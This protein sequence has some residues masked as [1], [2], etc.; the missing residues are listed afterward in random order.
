MLV[1]VAVPIGNPKDISQRAIEHLKS[2]Q[3]LILEERGAGQRWLKYIGVQKEPSCIYQLNEHSKQEDIQELTGL[4]ENQEVALITDAG[5]PGFCDPGALLVKAC[6]QKG[7]PVITV[8][9]ASSL[10]CLLS[11]S[12]LNIRQFYFAGFL[13]AENEE[14][15]RTL[16]KLKSQNDAIVVMDTPYRLKKMANEI[17]THFPQRKILFCSNLTQEDEIQIECQ[18]TKLEHEL[19]IRGLQKTEFIILIYPKT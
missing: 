3:S 10:T 16:S 11:L 15:N 8:P 18:G 12:S 4:C 1:L 13:P 6:R 7:I 2:C 17:A 14:R 5:T 9:G 19:Q